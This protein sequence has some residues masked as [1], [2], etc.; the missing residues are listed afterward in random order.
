MVNNH[1]TYNQP[2][3]GQ[4]MQGPIPPPQN[5]PRG[6]RERWMQRFG[7]DMAV[8]MQKGERT[9]PNWLTGKSMVFFF[10]AMFACWMAFGYVPSFDLWFTAVISIVLFFYGGQ[11]MSKGWS[12]SKEK[13]FIKNIFIAGVV[14]RFLWVLYCYFFFNPEHYGTAYGDGSDVDWY[15][16]FAKDLALWLTGDSSMT[17]SEIID[18]NGSAIDDIGYPLWLAVGYAIWGDWSDVFIPM[19]VKCLV[20]AYCAISIY[21][22]AKRHFGEGTAR[23]AAIFVALNPNIIYWCGNMFKEADMVFLCC[24][25]VD[26][27]DRVLTSGKKYTFRALLPG[28]LAGLAL[29]FF[30]SALG[31]VFF[32]AVFAHIVMA[33]QRVMNTGKKVLAGLLVG[34]VL[35]VSMGDRIRTQSKDLV[36]K[37]QSDSQAQ[38]MEWRASRKYEK[39]GQQSFAKYASAAVF[40]PLIFTI[41]FPTFNAAHEGQLLQLQLSG[42]SYIKNILSFFVILVMIMML[43]S[44]EWRRHVFILAYT[45][46]YLAV[47]VMSAFAQSGRFHMPIW[48][49]LMLFAA[50]GVQIAKT[51]AR[52]RRWLPIVLVIE[53]VACLA[54]NWFKLKGRG[55]I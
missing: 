35:V 4:M 10:V 55:M 46:G 29:M 3:M 32:L 24:L 7:M 51:N 19:L 50:Y 20:G 16:P 39:G 17:F 9:I 2:P 45:L 8:P 36:E 1:N 23:L 33:S 15:M 38:N 25:A 5:R 54:W 28:I 47:L 37:V 26:N 44:G 31:I 48:P 52:L 18:Y 30:R 13:V 40:A 22:V 12:R 21:R 11:T 53:V 43:I 14:I 6:W 41:P 34:A 49:M 27:F 42:G